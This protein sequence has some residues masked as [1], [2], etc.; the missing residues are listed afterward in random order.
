MSSTTARLMKELGSWTAAFALVALT[1]VYFDNIRGL[2]RTALE[3]VDMVQYRQASQTKPEKPKTFG[4]TVELLSDNL[5]HFQTTAYINGTPVYVLVDTGASLVSMSYDVAQSVGISI[6]DSDFTA[7]TQTANGI[8]HVA[9]VHIDEISIGGITISN[10]RG[11]VA[12]PG[13]QRKTLLGMT[14]LNRLSRFGVQSGVMVM[15]D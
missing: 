12:E 11:A 4:G 9:I 3:S 1:V 8:A 10:V 5:G 6:S 14:F 2:M 15:E 7:R 13:L